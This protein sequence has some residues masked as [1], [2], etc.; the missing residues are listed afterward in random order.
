MDAI[1]K[2][3]TVERVDTMSDTSLLV[4]GAP[5]PPGHQHARELALLSL[6]LLCEYGYE[7][8]PVV[9]GRIVIRPELRIG[10]HSGQNT[11]SS[12]ALTKGLASPSPGR[13]KNS[14]ISE[15]YVPFAKT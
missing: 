7:F 13:G 2:R 9:P 10:L 4:S 11:L 14:E 5:S 12:P 3:Y 1:A 6:H 8:Q 15:L